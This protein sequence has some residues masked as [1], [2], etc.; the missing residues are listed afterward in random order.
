ME[1]GKRKEGVRE[2][3][4][5]GEDGWRGRGER[6]VGREGGSGPLI[7]VLSLRV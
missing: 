2:G 6:V 7:V 1:A 4:W 5:S 3:G